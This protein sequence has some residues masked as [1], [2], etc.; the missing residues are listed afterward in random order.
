MVVVVVLL[1]DDRAM[2]ADWLGGAKESEIID[3]T[4]STVGATVPRIQQ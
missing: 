1:P 3:M 2:M 4:L